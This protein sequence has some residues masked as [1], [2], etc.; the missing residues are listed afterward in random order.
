VRASVGT[1]LAFSREKIGRL[2]GWE[3]EVSLEAGI[4]RLVAWCE[5]R[6]AKR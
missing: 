1:Q 6:D 4:R 5:Q 2:L 3:P